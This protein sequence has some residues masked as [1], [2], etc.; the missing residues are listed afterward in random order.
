MKGKWCWE[1]RKVNA[2]IVSTLAPISGGAYRCLPCGLL[3]PVPV[4]LLRQWP[5]SATPLRGVKGTPP[6]PSVVGFS[7]R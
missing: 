2:G 1:A 7:G 5:C 3:S 4:C 6:E